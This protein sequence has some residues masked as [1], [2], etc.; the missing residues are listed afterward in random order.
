[1]S[2]D[3]ELLK[4]YYAKLKRFEIG[5]N[6]HVPN[7][8]EGF[9]SIFLSVNDDFSVEAN[10][11]VW[12]VDDVGILYL[13][14]ISPGFSATAHFAFWDRRFK[15][16]EELIRRML[17]YCFEKYGFHRIEARIAMYAN[18]MMKAVERIGFTKEGRLRDAVLKSGEWYDVNL[19][20]ILESEVRNGAKA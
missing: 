5:F 16:R 1:V 19:Y 15:G 12:E 14:H 18:G 13:T 11:L 20:S 17:D 9:A 8:P 2:L 3:T 7:S 6:D 10:G 4:K